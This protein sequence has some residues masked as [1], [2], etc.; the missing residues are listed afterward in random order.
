MLISF[1]QPAQS[2]N[3]NSETRTTMM[4]IKL[5][6]TSVLLILFLYATNSS[7]EKAAN[8]TVGEL[9][10]RVQYEQLLPIIDYCDT[11]LPET[12]KRNNKTY[13]GFI[14]KVDVGVATVEKKLGASWKKPIESEK[15]EQTV[16]L[17]KKLTQ[18]TLPQIEKL[19]AENY[20]PG[21]FTKL[22]ETSSDTLAETMIRAYE[23]YEARQSN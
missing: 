18:S 4:T 19:G 23:D 14:N 1:V 22:K 10:K 20:C 3:L 13:Q 11:A 21:F 2:M 12:K 16:S 8:W 6:N 17:M 7:A 9:F 15:A 5:L